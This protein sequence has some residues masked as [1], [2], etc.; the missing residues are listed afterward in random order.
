ML[1]LAI[2]LVVTLLIVGLL[3]WAIDSMPWINAN[4]KTMINIVV[5]VFAVLWV[6]QLM[7]PMIRSAVH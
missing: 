4:V 6:L 3:L 5:I 1:N 7:V 2:T